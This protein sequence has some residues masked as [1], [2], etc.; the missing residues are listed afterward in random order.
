M[1]ARH[2]GILARFLLAALHLYRLLLRPLLP[3]ACRFH[4]TCSDY[5]SEAVTRFGAARGLLLAGARL[6]RC[7]P[8]HPGGPD[9]VPRRFTLRTH[10]RTHEEAIP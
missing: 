10:C 8:F 2:P 9:P 5:A 4:P 7:H 6:A 1:A 3:S